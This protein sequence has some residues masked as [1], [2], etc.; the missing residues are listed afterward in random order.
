MEVRGKKLEIRNVPRKISILE[1]LN[2]VSSNNRNRTYFQSYDT[3]TA[4][5]K[6]ET[7]TPLIQKIG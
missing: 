2:I 1:C 6:N 7:Q 4:E 5:F 3:I